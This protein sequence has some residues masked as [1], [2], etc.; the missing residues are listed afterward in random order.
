MLEKIRE[1]SQGV[2]AMVVLGLVILSFVFAGV[3][4]YVTAPTDNAAAVVNGEEISQSTLERAY[5]NER[6]RMEA[7]FG[8]AFSMLAADAEY[9]KN[10]R[11]GILDRLIG[12]KL[13]EQTA[14]E[15]GLRVSDAQIREAIR[16]MPEFQIAGQF[17]N[18]RFQII[19]RQS[20][21][22]VNTFRDYMR[23]EMTRQQVAR[24]IVGSEFSLPNES[25]QAHELQQQ[26]RDIRFATIGSGQ[27]SDSVELSEEEI[28]SYYEMNLDRFDTQEQVSVAYVELKVSDFMGEVTT[29]EQDLLDFYERSSSSYRTEEER[30]A[31]HILVE[32]GEDKDAAQQDAEALL[33]RVQAGEDFAALAASSSAD[34]FSAENGGDLD[35]FGRGVMDPAFEEATFALANVGDVTSVVESEFGFH[36]IK[37]TDLKA[38]QVTP[39]EEVRAAIE[40]EVKTEKASERFFEV[41]Q[42]MSEIAFEVPDT[43]EDITSELGIDVKTAPLF[44]RI[45]PPEALSSPVV[46]NA[47]F[48][49]ELIEDRVNSDVLEVANEHVIVARVQEHEPART[50]AL[51]EVKQDI[52]SVLTA[53]KAQAAAKAWSETLMASLNEGTDVAAQLAEKSSAWEDK[54]GVGR[55]GSGVDSSIAA[56]AFKLSVAEGQN[57]AVVEL[58]NGDV[59]LVE[60]TKINAPTSPEE[61][62]LIGLAQR[63]QTTISQDTYAALVESLKAK[64][65]IATYSL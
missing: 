44:S 20:G 13:I 47:V 63:L 1:G 26:T 27:F 9:L 2:W 40:N 17:N 25:V 34:S 48:S 24:A 60:L 19:L 30:R 64:A 5:Q 8:D 43:L 11:D 28:L 12:D 57:Y 23:L 36:I 58:N 65:D 38:E 39:F 21:Y 49:P 7:Q 10:F 37:L 15:L 59:S 4:S 62:E 32:F 42:R 54:S 61:Q 3:G 31:S 33:Q 14:R 29:T 52:S 16:A 41:Q 18:D 50:K 35:W 6:G 46:V 45:A 56:E 22:Q 55:F 53:E 51:E